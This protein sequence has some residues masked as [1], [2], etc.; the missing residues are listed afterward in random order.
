MGQVGKSVNVIVLYLHR[1]LRL[2]P[3]VGIGIVFYTYVVPHFTAGPYW[4]NAAANWRGVWYVI[5]TAAW[6]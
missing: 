4:P 6:W 2:T 3:S 5:A 1:W